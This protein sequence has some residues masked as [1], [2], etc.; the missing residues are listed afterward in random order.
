[1]PP[2]SG[3]YNET[4]QTIA[5][6]EA[7]KKAKARRQKELKD[8]VCFVLLV[9]KI[10]RNGR[11]CLVFSN[12]VDGSDLLQSESER[13][14]A[15]ALEEYNEEMERINKVAAASRLTAEEKRRSAERK[16]RDKAHTIRST[17]KLPGRCGC[18]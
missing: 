16:A 13:K 12:L 11:P 3:R 7:D 15:K 18:F 17:G 8:E 4:M 10:Y 6:W 2:I 5:E 14:R 1:L 9:Q